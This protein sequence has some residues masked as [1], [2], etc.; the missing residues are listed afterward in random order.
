MPPDMPGWG[1]PD[2]GCLRVLLV[3]V[4]VSLGAPAVTLALSLWL[5]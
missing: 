5:S 2:K 3:V 1:N 4:G